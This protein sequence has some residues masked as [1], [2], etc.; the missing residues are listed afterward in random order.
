MN[1]VHRNA[2]FSLFSCVTKLV[3]H[4]YQLLVLYLVATTVCSIHRYYGTVFGSHNMMKVIETTDSLK[5]VE[6]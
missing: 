3:R 2:S 1:A 4:L 6:Y 5:L